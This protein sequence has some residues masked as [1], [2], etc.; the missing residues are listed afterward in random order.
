MTTKFMTTNHTDHGTRR[1]KGHTIVGAALAV[2]GFFWL[3]KKIGWIPVALSGSVIFWPAVTI[4]VG[5]MITLS[6]RRS[7]TPRTTG[8]PPAADHNIIN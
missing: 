2:I 7:H 4:A 6:A 3:A 5:I 8:D 1:T